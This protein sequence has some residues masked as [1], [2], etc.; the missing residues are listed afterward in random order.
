MIANRLEKI[1]QYFSHVGFSGDELESVATAFELK[2]FPKGSL[3][4][5]EGRTSRHMGLVDA[6]LFQYFVLK[7]GQEITHYVSVPDTWM[8]SV[9]SFVGEKPALENVRALTDGSIY[10]ISRERLKQLVN[11]IPKFK[12]FY[13]LLLEQ[14]ISGIDESRHDMI[15]LSAD[16]R[17]A[18][19]LSRQPH[20]LQMIPLQHLASMLGITPRHLSRIRG[21]IR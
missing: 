18:K 17:Y 6:G 7:D 1:R 12:D 15:V 13:I 19:L 8:A 14:S 2:F 5:T 16:Q 4:V 9:M 20:L 3:V 21:S 10:L 11:D